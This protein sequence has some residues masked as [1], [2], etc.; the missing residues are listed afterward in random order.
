MLD[1]LASRTTYI[2]F[3]CLHRSHCFANCM[4]LQEVNYSPYLRELERVNETISQSLK[5]RTSG[6]MLALFTSDC[7]RL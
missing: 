6:M 7:M 4:F 3:L 2:I 1:G 5:A